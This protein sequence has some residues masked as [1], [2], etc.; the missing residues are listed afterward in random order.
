MQ[1]SIEKSMH[2]GIDFWKDFGGFLEA[3]WRHVGTNIEQ[4]SMPTS[5]S[6]FL[7]NLCFSIGKTMILRVQGIEVGGKNR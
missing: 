5:K 7:E 4:K 1:K 2:L 6:D 3:K